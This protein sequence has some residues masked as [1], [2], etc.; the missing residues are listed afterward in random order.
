MVTVVPLYERVRPVLDKLPETRDEASAPGV[1]SGDIEFRNLTFRY[2]DDM[3]AVLDNISFHIHPGDY[4]AIVGRSGDATSLRTVRLTTVGSR[5]WIISDLL[6]ATSPA[7][8]NGVKQAS[9]IAATQM[10]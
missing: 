9:A 2:R 7:M 5:L 1:L 6:T 4:V 8:A 3:P 10:M